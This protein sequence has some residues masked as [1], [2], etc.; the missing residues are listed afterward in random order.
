MR[1]ITIKHYSLSFLCSLVLSCCC[2]QGISKPRTSVIFETDM[3]NDIDDALA[4]AMLFRYADQGHINLLGVVNNKESLSSVQFL[5]IM[6]KQYGYPDLP[7]ATVQQG[8][9]GEPEERSFARKTMDYKLYGKRAFSSGIQGYSQVDSAIHLYRKLL[10]SAEDSSVVIISVGFSTNIA[11]LLSSKADCYSMLNG[12]EL[13]EKKVKYLSIM[14]GSF[15]H[16]PRHREFNIISDISA[17]QSLF[18]KWPTKI[19]VSPFEVGSAIRFPATSI[20]QNLGY[21]ALHPLVEAYKLYLPMPYDR[22]TWD[23][24]A[25]LFAVEMDSS[26]FEVSLPGIIN[27]DNNG[28]TTFMPESNGIHYYLKKPDIEEGKRI[29]RRFVELIHCMSK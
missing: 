13:V 20:I 22:E 18:N 6:R 19:Y 15:V 8:V 14:G 12:Y 4:L 7:L 29:Q 3:G 25:V 1:K 5:D 10:A 9:Q 23:L 24:T 16:E 17:A 11:R 27:V 28:Y 26:Y 2:I 21:T